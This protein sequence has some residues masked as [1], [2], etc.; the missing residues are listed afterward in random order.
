MDITIREATLA[1][2]EQIA[3]LSRQTFYE[4]FAPYNTEAD[5]EIF[6]RETFT[7]EAL[8]AEVGAPGNTFLLAFN[9]DQLAGYARLREQPNDMTLSSIEIARLYAA[10]AMIGKGVGKALMQACIDFAREQQK[11]TVWLGVWEKNERAIR[12]YTAWG[13]EKVGEH[14]FVLGTDV[15]R[16]WIM[17]KQLWMMR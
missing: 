11:K 12:F 8:I 9:K 3:D 4:T 2:A 13:F 15:Q 6:M 5:M 7:R 17:E 14:D 16:D 1:D 10:T